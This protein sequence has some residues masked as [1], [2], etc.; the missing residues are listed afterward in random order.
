MYDEKFLHSTD[1]SYTWNFIVTLSY[2][3]S[4][5]NVL[6]QFYFYSSLSGQL[7]PSCRLIWT[8]FLL[9]QF[10]ITRFCSSYRIEVGYHGI[11]LS[12]LKRLRW[13]HDFLRLPGYIIFDASKCVV[14][15]CPWSTLFSKSNLW[16]NFESKPSPFMFYSCFCSKM[17]EYV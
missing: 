12:S 17:Q 16:Q 2:K 8:G 11:P 9:W 5:C 6:N 4:F 3:I 14:I 1:L 13:W 10:L 15:C 7:I